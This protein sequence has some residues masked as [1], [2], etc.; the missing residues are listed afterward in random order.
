MCWDD[1]KYL[2]AVMRGGSLLGAARLSG[3]D[4]TTVARRIAALETALG[5]AL[6]QRGAEGR[7]VLTALG[8][9]AALRAEAMEDAARGLGA[10]AGEV[11]TGRVRVT[12]V[13][14]MVN[15]LLLPR[16]AELLADM[17][18]LSLELIAEA[19]DLSLT[20][21]DADIAIRLA[22]PRI[23][24]RAVLA[25]RIG[26][27]RY[28]IYAARG[29]PADLPWIGYDPTMQYLGHAAAI[30]ANAARPCERLSPL[31]FNDAE[32]LYQAVLAGHGKSLLPIPVAEADGRL[33]PRPD[34]GADC[35]G[36]EVWLLVLRDLAGLA[37]ITRTIAWI[38]AVLGAATGG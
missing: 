4:K 3:A 9:R 1:L 32:T 2:L 36:R 31:S 18:G 7:L 12:S 20:Q 24:G 23:G 8:E 35:P 5:G 16:A 17:P 33:A 37:R 27:L 29:A 14:L 28:G 34:P 11:P 30:A 10:T 25:R 26:T 15:H 21:R 19:R 13:P 38:E 6:V 22:R